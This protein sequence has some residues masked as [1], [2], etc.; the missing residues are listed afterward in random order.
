M[1]AFNS[2]ICS[3]SIQPLSA[4]IT[5]PPDDRWILSMLSSH[6]TG[7]SHLAQATSPGI[8]E[9]LR[10]IGG[11]D[12]IDCAKLIADDQLQC[13]GKPDQWNRISPDDCQRVS[14][15]GPYV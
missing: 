9:L 2:D 6:G 15:S 13:P 5:C 3:S 10:E 8:F 4:K 1:S 14:L 7:I 12:L 11:G